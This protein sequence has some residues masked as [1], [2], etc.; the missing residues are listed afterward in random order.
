MSGELEELRRRAYG[1]P[2][3][4]TDAA[5]AQAELQRLADGERDATTWSPTRAPAVAS[6]GRRG[7]LLLGAAT[8]VAAALATG[9]ALAPTPS[10]DVF[11]APQQ[12]VPTWPGAP[13]GD[14]DIR[15]LGSLGPWEVFGLITS[16]GNVCVTAFGEG[17]SAGGSC[18]SRA[19]FAMN[20]LKLRTSVA[21]IPGSLSVQW[22]PRGDASLFDV[23]STQLDA[24]G[25]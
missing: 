12:G 6:V 1:R 17:D 18:T 14:D 20:G 10:L 24:V 7:T 23:P 8:L 3:S 25:R 15:W 11:A 21:T 9:I 2:L 16:G 5:T 13:A 4:E 22:G 19:E